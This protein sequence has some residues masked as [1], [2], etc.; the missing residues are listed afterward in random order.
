LRKDLQEFEEA[1]RRLPKFLVASGHKKS[2][3]FRGHLARYWYFLKRV[4]QE[5][6]L[7]ELLPGAVPGAIANPFLRKMQNPDSLLT[8]KMAE[9]EQIID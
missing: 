9:R 2:N 5:P 6:E 3:L 4:L 8:P 7:A 1:V